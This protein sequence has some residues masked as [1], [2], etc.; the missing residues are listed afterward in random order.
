MKKY[1]SLLLVLFMIVFM[2][3]TINAIETAPRFV[4]SSVSG[5]CGDIVDVKVMEIAL[6]IVELRRIL[7]KV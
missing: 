6:K 2:V 1:I 4:V 5:E 7:Q 3:P